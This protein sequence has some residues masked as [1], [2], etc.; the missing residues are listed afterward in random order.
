MVRLFLLS[1]AYVFL[2]VSAV[3]ADDSKEIFFESKVRPILIERCHSCHS[4]DEKVKGE[5]LLDSRNGWQVGGTLGPAVVPG[6][7]DE[8]L[9]VEAVRY[10][11][12][13]LEM[14]PKGKLPPHEIAILEEWVQ[15]GAYDPRIDESVTASE[16]I[17]IEK[18]KEFWS[19][20][21]VKKP[22]LNGHGH[23]L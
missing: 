13:D 12:S 5:L 2:T 10:E 21:P 22:V 8:S 16:G 4:K 17:D 6:K 3:F 9:V 14:P 19:F 11:N 1:S 18:G 15:R 7:P 23:Q 20:R